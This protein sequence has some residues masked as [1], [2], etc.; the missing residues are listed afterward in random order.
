MVVKNAMWKRCAVVGADAANAMTPTGTRPVKRYRNGM[1]KQLVQECRQ[2]RKTSGHAG[3]RHHQPAN[4][5][6]VVQ[7]AEVR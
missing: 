6:V 7:E 4:G 1:A 5:W 2:P 3:M